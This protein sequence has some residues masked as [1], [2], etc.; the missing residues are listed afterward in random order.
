VSVEGQVAGSYAH[1][2]ENS[3]SIEV[4]ELY[5][6]SEEPLASQEEFCAKEPVLSKLVTTLLKCFIVN[7]LV[8]SKTVSVFVREINSYF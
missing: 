3:E 2:S 8:C 5:Q 6:L 1:G 4:L 7:C